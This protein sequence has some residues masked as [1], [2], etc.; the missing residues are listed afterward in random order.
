MSNNTTCV[1]TALV[2][3]AIKRKFLF[4]MKSVYFRGSA[5]EDMRKNFVW[6]SGGL[7][8]QPPKASI[9]AYRLTQCH[10]L[11]KVLPCRFYIYSSRILEMYRSYN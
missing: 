6:R 5:L 11:T 4:L 3:P 7:D 10:D 9:Y 2:S 8:L 1:N